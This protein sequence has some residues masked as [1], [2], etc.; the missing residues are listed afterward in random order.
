ML[1]DTNEAYCFEQKMTCQIILIKIKQ[2]DSIQLSPL[3]LDPNKFPWHYLTLLHI[4]LLHNYSQQKNMGS[5]IVDACSTRHSYLP[6]PS[7][8]G[9]C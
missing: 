1:L 4:Y 2:L 7:C 3:F 8:A 5:N 6:F 9:A